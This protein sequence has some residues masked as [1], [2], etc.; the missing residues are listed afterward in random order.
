[1]KRSPGR[2][3]SALALTGKKTI[4]SAAGNREERRQVVVPPTTLPKNAMAA[5]YPSR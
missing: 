1:M 5:L 2:R 4:T 3:R